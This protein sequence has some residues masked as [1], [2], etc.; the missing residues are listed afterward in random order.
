MTGK[1]ETPATCQGD[2]PTAKRLKLAT[3]L[4]VADDRNS[5]PDDNI[6]RED[7]LV[8]CVRCKCEVPR[9]KCQVAYQRSKTFKCNVCNCNMVRL[10]RALG[11][12]PIEAFKGW[13]EEEKRL[14]YVEIKAMKGRDML[15]TFLK[16]KFSKF[17]RKMDEL[18]EQIQIDRKI[19]GQIDERIR[20]GT[21][22]VRSDGQIKFYKENPKSPA[23]ARRRRAK[24]ALEAAK[25]APLNLNNMIA[26][27]KALDAIGR[28]FQ[29]MH[30]LNKVMGFQVLGQWGVDAFN[31][32]RHVHICA[33]A[34]IQ[35]RGYIVFPY[36]RDCRN[37]KLKA[38]KKASEAL[39]RRKGRDLIA[40]MHRDI[41]C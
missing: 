7:E 32:L 15:L 30:R 26:A 25:T 24:S 16:E 4:V 21:F 3:N 6:D 8:R 28:T 34:T 18:A 22:V 38:A 40:C 1:E 37:T 2:R 33:E 20:K 39:E 17:G 27:R 9:N 5:K 13:N 19:E 36:T 31:G 23:R 12:W 35:S 41:G 10:S 14:F 11:H 29:W